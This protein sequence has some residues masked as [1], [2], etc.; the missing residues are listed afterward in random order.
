MARWEIKN[1]RLAGVAATMPRRVVKTTDFDF[2]TPEEADT[3]I[4]TVGIRERRLAPESV[5]ASDLC[6]AAAERLLEDLGWERSSVDVL[7]F[8]SVTGDYHPTPPTSCILQDRLGLPET[9]FCVDI[10]MGCCGC[11][12][13]INVAGNML[14]S[15]NVKRAL[16]LVGDTAMR[17]GSLKDKSRVPLF[18]DCGTAL[19]LEYKEGAEDIV[20][21]FHTYGA[22][23]KA[24]MTPHGG[25]RNPITPAS[26]E[27]EDFGNGIV[28]AP[29]HT[30]IE[31]MNVL[32]F[33]ISR[34]PKT[35]EQF[36]TDYQIDRNTDID[37][38]LI[39]QANKMI[40]DRIVKKMK[41]PIEKVPYNL[42]EFGNLGGASI[43]S[44]MVTRLAEQLKEN[45]TKRLLCSS[46][47]L[48]LSWG[49]ML[50]QCKEVVVSEM[51]EV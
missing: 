10:P 47:G 9:T 51:V 48:G 3:F 17:M 24:L 43:P 46:F 33:A 35:M 45:T 21:D 32:A 25:F 30:L 40:V 2:F 31:G 50:L 26:F 38:F 4:K 49:T 5:C 8:E 36:L 22:G 37:F 27:Y 29:M 16:L 19:A 13:A 11:M 15:G 1:V 20:I 18:G 39:H 14:S 44:L 7:V 6:Q 41:F 34:P 12:Y 28:R 42:E 23:Y